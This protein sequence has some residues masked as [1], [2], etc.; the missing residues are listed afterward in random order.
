MSGDPVSDQEARSMADS[1][2]RSAAVEPPSTMH[3]LIDA[4]L[5]RAPDHPLVLNAAGG[6]LQ[7]SGDPA[8]AR[9]LFE[10]A[11]AADGKSKVLWLN[12][13]GAC[14]ALGDSR[15]ESD[16][17]ERALSIDPRYVLALLQK[18]DLLERLD[19]EKNAA[20]AYEAALDCIASGIATPAQAGALL[21]HA[22]SVVQ[23]NR[24]R[25]EEYL[26][27][28]LAPVRS[29]QADADLTRYQGCEETL[30]RKRRVYVSQP[31]QIHFPYL[32]ATEFF[33][34]EQFAW[35]EMLE[36][37]TGQIAAEAAAALQNNWD[38]FKPYVDAPDS[39]PLDQWAA[40]NRSKQ[41]SVYSLWHDGAPVETHTARCPHAARVLEQMPLCD[42]PGWAPGAY[43]SVL[44]PRT[45]LPPHTGSTNT[46]VIVHLPLLV[47]DGCRFRVGSQTRSVEKGRAWVFDDSIEHEAWNDSDIPRV[48]L[49]FDIWNPLLTAA[50]RNMVRG[51]TSAVGRYYQAQSRY[52]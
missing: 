43:F 31:K 22:Q 44:Q 24:L 20:L 19:Q 46:R 34:R 28:E 51:M 48:I 12:L 21:A 37:A 15:I 36:S 1:I 14:R 5:A 50:E 40:L 49:I 18:G 32:A 41:W 13:A 42:I 2:V 39:T 47:P 52:R 23:N 35:L 11:V 17:L 7:R 8:R 27:S 3:R 16:A 25:L 45:H 26:R 10:R 9:D 30:L 6:Y 29:Q 38:E 33:A 4:A